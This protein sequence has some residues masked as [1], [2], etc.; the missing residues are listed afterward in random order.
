MARLRSGN[1]P[2][3]KLKCAEMT[4]T[5]RLLVGRCASVCLEHDIQGWAKEWSLGCVNI[6]LTDLC[7]VVPADVPWPVELPQHLEEPVVVPARTLHLL[8][9]YL[10]HVLQES[11]RCSITEI[12][13]EIQ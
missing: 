7:D 6:I 1:L 2:D 5:R 10:P 8:V 11:G 9:D 3:S 12:V 4:P 13:T